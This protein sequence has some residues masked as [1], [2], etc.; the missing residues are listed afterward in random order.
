MFGY[1][2]IY[3]QQLKQ[4]DEQD[5]KKVYCALCHQMSLY[6]SFSRL[7]LSFDMT[8]LIFLSGYDRKD[9]SQ[10]CTEKKCLKK[11]PCPD[12][13]ID[14]WA[15]LSIMLIYQKILNDQKDGKKLSRL[16]S[17]ALK[18]NW[19][20]VSEKYPVAR[21]LICKTLDQ[22]YALEEAGSSDADTL[23]RNFGELAAGLIK[24]APANPS[25]PE[26][27]ENLLENIGR[28][29]GEWIYFVDFYDDVEKD[30]HEGQYNPI[31]LQAEETGKTINEVKE[32]FRGKINSIVTELQRLCA[33]L[34][35]DGY[36]AIIRNVLHEGVVSVTGN[37]FNGLT[38]NG[39]A[40]HHR[41]T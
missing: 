40:R 13:L 38:A 31:I 25:R 41:E 11:V 9:I 39:Q 17:R 3:P 5:Y 32:E 37:I 34:P 35:Y 30:K 6:S 16:F 36:Q 15:C 27:L 10:K 7:F 14:Y 28:F 33:F 1:V 4:V 29:V 21:D 18:Y 8:F 12:P 23:A 26:E 2:K 22:N 20:E 19:N 24:N